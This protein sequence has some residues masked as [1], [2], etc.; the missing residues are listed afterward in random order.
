[1][2]SPGFCQLWTTDLCCLGRV[3][4]LSD[5]RHIWECRWGLPERNSGTDVGVM[6]DGPFHHTLGSLWSPSRWG[7]TVHFPWVSSSFQRADEQR[8]DKSVE[9][10]PGAQFGCGVLLLNSILGSSFVSVGDSSY[11]SP[12]PPLSPKLSFKLQGLRGTL[13]LCLWAA[14]RA[15]RDHEGRCSLSLFWTRLGRLSPPKPLSRG[16]SAAGPTV[17]CQD[18]LWFSLWWEVCTLGGY[19]AEEAREGKLLEDALVN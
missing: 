10:L 9:S 15:G 6:Q 14:G 16:W 19:Q 13:P 11:F 3:C 8:K 17:F 12:P 1:M 18:G 5:K 4:S 7:G 2:E